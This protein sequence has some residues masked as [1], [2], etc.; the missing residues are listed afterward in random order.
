[1]AGLGAGM[2]GLNLAGMGLPGA[3][4][5]AAALGA[6]G[7]PGMTPAAAVAAPASVFLMMCN[8]PQAV[9]E[10][11]VRSPLL[12]DSETFHHVSEIGGE[13]LE[14]LTRM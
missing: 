6:L 2:T 3:G 10:T 1:M 13:I 8:I 4:A 5:G 11:S 12:T 9:D 14:T 7:V